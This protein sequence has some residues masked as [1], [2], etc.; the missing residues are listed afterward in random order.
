MKETIIDITKLDK[1]PSSWNISYFKPSE[2]RCKCGKCNSKI[3]SLLVQ[4]L[5]AIREYTGKAIKI[6][7]AYR[8]TSHNKAVGGASSSQHLY[9]KAA[10]IVI[11][12]IDPGCVQKAM[13]SGWFDKGGVGKY[14]TFTHVDTGPQRTFTVGTQSKCT[15]GFPKYEE[16]KPKKVT[17]SWTEGKNI[18]RFFDDKG[19]LVKT[20]QRNVYELYYAE[21]DKNEKLEKEIE[22]EKNK[23]NELAKENIEL[24][25]SNNNCIEE[26][27]ESKKLFD[28]IKNFFKK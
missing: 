22:E 1:F 27:G 14:N 13:Q 9:G 5:Q 16:P 26:N 7:S 24:K 23:C 12:G 2:F 4:R 18:Y 19:N 20:S 25:N 15:T 6:N 28:V 17:V 3:S 11:D 8:C 21:Q 10:D